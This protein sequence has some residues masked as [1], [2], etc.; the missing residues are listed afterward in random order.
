MPNAIYEAQI[1]NNT[2]NQH[3][4][5]LVQ[6]KLYLRK[7]I[8]A[9]GEIL[10]I[11]SRWF[12]SNFQTIF[13]VW[14]IKEIVEWRIVKKANIKVLPNYYKLQKSFFLIKPLDDSNLLNKISGLVS[15]CRHQN[16]LPL[17]NI[18]RSDNMDWCL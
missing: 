13:E 17:C 7:D 15:K 5:I 9:T 2:N 11:K 8:A 10:N 6:L 4:S 12:V 3:K 14:R 18:K 1:T 16:K